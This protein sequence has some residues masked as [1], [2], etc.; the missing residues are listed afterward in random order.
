MIFAFTKGGKS[1]ILKQILA[2]N[3]FSSKFI[4]DHFY[5]SIN[6]YSAG[7]LN[8][9]ALIVTPLIEYFAMF[10]HKIHT[11]N[12]DVGKKTIIYF[13]NKVRLCSN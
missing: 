12:N 4:F 8:I 9:I 3:Y 5:E 7:L 2:G 1:A 10:V 11:F 13:S 6:F